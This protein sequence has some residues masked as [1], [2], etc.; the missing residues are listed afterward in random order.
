MPW[1]L[2]AFVTLLGFTL[3]SLGYSRISKEGVKPPVLLCIILFAGS[4]YFLAGIIT[5][6]LPAP[7]I[8]ALPWILSM[9]TICWIGNV[10]QTIS[11]HRSP[12]PGFT[13][14]IIG[15]QSPFV[16][17]VAIPMFGDP[18]NW[19]KFA[20]MILCLGGLSLLSIKHSESKAGKPGWVL[21][22]I[23]AMVGIGW[24]TLTY[25][26]LGLMG[27]A[28]DWTN[29]G[30]MGISTVF[31]LIHAKIAKNP[32]PFGK[33]WNLKTI[34][35]WFALFIIG[36]TGGSACQAIA[37]RD[38]PNPGYP[39]SIISCDGLLTALI[40]WKFFKDELTPRQLCGALLCLA[41]LVVVAWGGVR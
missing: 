22:G 35:F 23:I 16:A 32:F 2:Y 13:A 33:G 17:L 30:M 4:L 9:A 29:F 34:W 26:K 12:N 18:L 25:R 11:N 10:L 39:I 19:L 3:C 5:K 14:A 1:Q 36:S 7:P 28:P 8:E 41:G 6:D 38:A 40:A 24:N 15:C 20:G 31:N 21:L 37:F 27:V